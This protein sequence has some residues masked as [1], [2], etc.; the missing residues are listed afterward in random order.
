ML[1]QTSEYAVRAVLYLAMHADEGPVKLEA[2]AGAL[3]A[4]R[5]YL[6]K[7]LSQLA[8]AG[9]L[10]SGRGQRGGFQLAVPAERRT[11]AAIVGAFEPETLATNCLLG[12]GP[13]SDETP[14]AAHALWKPVAEPMRA[15]FRETTVAD[16]VSG[17]AVHRL[18]P[19]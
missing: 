5:N 1:S 19:R 9:V 3:G 12:A 4:P 13:C 10:S 2:V 14:C 15:F 11:L 17:T 6:S 7:T 8:R 18:A 16:L